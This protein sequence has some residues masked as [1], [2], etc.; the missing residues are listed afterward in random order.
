MQGSIGVHMG[1]RSIA[2]PNLRQVKQTVTLPKSARLRLVWFDY[3]QTHGRNAALTARYFGI[4]KSCFF[5]WKRRY[6][7]LGPRGLID[8]PKRPKTTRSPLT[9][10]PVVTAIRSLRKANPEY[11]KYKLQVILKRDYGYQVSASTVGR[12]I[13]RHQLFFSP[14]VRPKSHP[15][16]RTSIQRLRKPSSLRPSKPGDLVEV[17]VKHLPHLG[18]KHYGF[19]AIDVVSKQATVHVA[20]TI[21]SKQGAIAW[22]KA[23]ERLGLPKAALTDNGS[24]NLGAFAK[25]LQEQPTEHYFARPRTP[26]DKPHV[27]RFIGSLEKEFIQW[28]GVAIDLADQQALVN[29]WLNK[30]HN[31]RPHQSLGYLTPDEY[32]AKLNN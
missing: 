8:Q 21:S 7:R 2:P 9:P 6:D 16:R 23:V 31:Y 19:V 15:Y 12:V 27:E 32:L 28:G 1:L 17:D 13:S 4:A 30:Y 26:K 18:S 11:S 5:K 24:E 3:Y 22:R 25:L 10:A 14:P 20:S 29:T